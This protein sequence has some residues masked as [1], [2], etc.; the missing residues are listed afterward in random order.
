MQKRLQQIV[1]TKLTELLLSHSVTK[2]GQSSHKSEVFP[3]PARCLLALFFFGL[4][5]PRV[6]C[7]PDTAPVRRLDECA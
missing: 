4:G 5:G 7:V 1:K 2:L 6:V 3:Q